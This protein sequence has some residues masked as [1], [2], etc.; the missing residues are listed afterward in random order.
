MT[1]TTWTSSLS[2]RATRCRGGERAGGSFLFCLIR[3]T[4]NTDGKSKI[5]SIYLGA[6]YKGDKEVLMWLVGHWFGNGEL[7]VC[8][9]WASVLSTFC[10]CG[11]GFCFFV[12]FCVFFQT[13]NINFFPSDLVL[14]NLCLCD[15]QFNVRRYTSVCTFVKLSFVFLMKSVRTC[16]TFCSV[17]NNNKSSG[18]LFL[19]RE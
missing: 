4:V 14:S 7:G 19:H 17:Y 13:S 11:S 6:V 10:Q 3:C 1:A 18:K 15:A 16:V 5:C 2:A 8:L 12:G 9:A